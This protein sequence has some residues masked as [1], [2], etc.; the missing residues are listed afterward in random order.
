M[1]EGPDGKTI[2]IIKKVSGHG[3]HHGGAWK[4]AFADFVTAM[5]ALFMVLWLVNSAAEPTRERI[6]SYF[7]KPGIFQKGSG[8][9]MEMGG[10][11]ILPDMFS[12]QTDGNSQIQVSD[13]IYTVDATSGRVRE[14]YD[15]GQG[16]KEHRYAPKI[17]G[18]DARGLSEEEIYT[19]KEEISRE[20]DIEQKKLEE[21][22]TEIEKMLENSGSDESME[23]IL[24]EVEIKV[25]Q[26]GLVIE[27]MDTEKTSMFRSGQVQILSEA[28]SK[29]SEIA[30]VIQSVPNPIDI[31]GH[32]DSSPFKG[33]RSKVYDNWNLS[34]DRAH[35]ARRVLEGAGFKKG[36]IARVVGY[37]DE[38]PRDL[39]NSLNPANRRITISM[40][41][42]E[43]AKEALE[44]TQTFET[45]A[46]KKK[47]EEAPS[48]SD[49]KVLSDTKSSNVKTGSGFVVAAS[50]D[51]FKNQ[52]SG[53][54]VEVSTTTPDV[55]EQMSVERKKDSD[56]KNLIFESPDSFFKK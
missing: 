31:E 46:T 15:E 1:P 39:E 27:I 11:G 47:V 24:G 48:A 50:P 33:A 17:E 28:E 35:A 3:G 21:L 23:G 44:G 32:T 36:Q 55:S 26:R 53:I 38:R 9:P 54:K 19:K 25:D 8:N 2:I 51:D 10:G 37:A 30:R 18:D 7:R 6:A 49:Q 45:S 41:Y 43:R 5:M 34:S 4:V 56:K 40:R 52:T 13:R 12:P 20:S 14:L 22:K 16:A 42:S 29:L